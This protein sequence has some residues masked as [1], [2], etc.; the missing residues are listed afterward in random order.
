[1]RDRIF[2]RDFL[3][4]STLAQFTPLERIFFLGL[5]CCA[6]RE[7][8]LRDQPNRLK[9]EILPYDEFYPVP[10]LEEFEAMDMIAR[11]TVDGRNYIQILHFEDY[12]RP[13]HKERA[14]KIP[15][16]S[17]TEQAKP[18]ISQ[19]KIK[20]KSSKS[21]ARTKQEPSK[22]DKKRVNPPDTDTDTDTDTVVVNPSYSPSLEEGRSSP[23]AEWLALLRSTIHGVEPTDDA[24]ALEARIV[25][26]LEG[27]DWK[28]ARQ[29]PVDDRGDGKR[30]YVDLAIT[31]PHLV[32]I[33]IDNKT[34]RKKSIAKL[35]AGPDWTRVIVLRG[36]V[37]N[38]PD[39]IDEVIGLGG[40]AVVFK[41]PS[42]AE[43]REYCASRGNGVDAQAF[44]AFYE[45]KGWKVGDQPMKSWR[46]SVV[47]WE[48]RNPRNAAGVKPANKAGA[49]EGKFIPWHIDDVR[50]F[51][52][53]KEWDT[54]FRRME[55]RYGMN[56]QKWP[57][58][59]VWLD[60]ATRAG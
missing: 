16:F 14:S 26:A 39:D 17:S 38:I 23:S 21:Q 32:G 29:Y 25:E 44:V 34:P 59:K 5:I 56:D 27:L 45:S 36:P 20:H 49:H 31:E 12:Q 3:L 50:E 28:V 43:V 33:E 60:E 54:Y 40:P 51:S 8:R 10:C 22:D 30:G 19:G 48:R 1:M 35:N 15:P 2:G 4:S 57:R 18:S 13:H 6:D 46:A 24:L 7:G 55:E 41:P 9:A 58:F 47:S 37:G 52:N 11:Y 53:T 42:V